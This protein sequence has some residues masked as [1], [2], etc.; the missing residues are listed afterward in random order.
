MTED[1]ARRYILSKVAVRRQ[2]VAI[3]KAIILEACSRAAGSE[4]L[5]NEVSKRH[6]A[7]LPKQVA[8]ADNDRLSEQ[9]DAIA[10]ALSW[11]TATIEAIWAL[12]HAGFLII[13][14]PLHGSAP[15]L[16]WTMMR[17]GSGSSSGWSFG[18]LQYQF[19]TSV[20]RALSRETTDEYLS[21]PDLYLRA[22]SIPDIHDDIRRALAEAVACFRAEL[23]TASVVMLG[24]ACEGAWLELG[25]SLL[26]V[27]P[28]AESNAFAKQVDVLED[29]NAGPARKIAAVLAIFDRQDV[30]KQFSIT[31]GVRGQ[32][33]R[34]V[35]N[36]SD[37]VRD[38]RNTVHF[39]VTA[40]TPNTYEKVATLL[41]STAKNFQILYRLKRAADLT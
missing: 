3:A 28:S 16:G 1:E 5:M 7:Q 25:A 36:W 15:A 24:K 37:A 21:D 19:P 38:S 10:T 18:E 33:L 14:G 30:F 31:S 9:L 20:R 26:R 34:D 6:E 40:A 35:S 41:L 11:R 23:F 13:D 2:Q 32:D 29:Y 4:S 12:V 22:I 8:L 17:G 39:G 27:I